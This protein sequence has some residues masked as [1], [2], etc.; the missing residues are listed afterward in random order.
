MNEI[1]KAG[2]RQS[3]VMLLAS[4]INSKSWLIAIYAL[5]PIFLISKNCYKNMI[6]LFR[7]MEE[8]LMKTAGYVMN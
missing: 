1:I 4:G 2:Y 3:E 7:N 5:N 6:K 8:I